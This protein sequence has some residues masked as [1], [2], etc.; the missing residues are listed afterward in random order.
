MEFDKILQYYY[1][2]ESDDKDFSGGP[3][4]KTLPSKCKGHGFNLLLGN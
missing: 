1:I 3:L 4:V 2:I